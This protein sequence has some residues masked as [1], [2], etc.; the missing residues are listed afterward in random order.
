MC[1]RVF[2]FYALSGLIMPTMRTHTRPPHRHTHTSLYAYDLLCCVA[3]HCG[4]VEK[5]NEAT[6]ETRSFSR[7]DR[8]KSSIYF[9][10]VVS[11][12]V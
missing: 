3:I 8:G 10:M 4:V 12:T 11:V 5:Q 7:W 2:L 6:A 9:V 1:V